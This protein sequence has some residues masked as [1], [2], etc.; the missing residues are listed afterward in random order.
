MR[1]M[2]FQGWFK[3]KDGSATSILRAVKRVD[4]SI[5]KQIVS[6][7]LKVASISKNTNAGKHYKG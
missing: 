3:R 5:T 7:K 1:V 4:F 6:R 2:V